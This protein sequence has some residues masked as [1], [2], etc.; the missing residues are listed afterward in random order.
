MEQIY[1]VLQQV[2]RSEDDCRLPPLCDMP[3]GFAHPSQPLAICDWEASLDRAKILRT[4][5]GSCF[6]RPPSADAVVALAADAVAAP[7]NS[8][9]EPLSQMMQILEQ[10]KA[11]CDDMEKTH[12][13]SLE[14]PLKHDLEHF[15]GSEAHVV[16][17]KDHSH[18]LPQCF[19]PLHPSSLE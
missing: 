9:P 13:G 16:T 2:S 8:N 18:G 17:L 11:Q 1:S 10:C 19:A 5:P 12:I 7:A 6:Y 4:C 14:D 3:Q 15:L